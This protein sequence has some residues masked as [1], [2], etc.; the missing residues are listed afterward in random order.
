MKFKGDI[1]ITDPCY[2]MKDGDWSKCNYGESMSRLGLTAYISE[3]TI[4]GD[5]S[6]TTWSTPR[7][8]VEAQLEE[9]NTLC[10]EQYEPVEKYGRGSVQ[11]KIYEDKIFDATLDLKD[12][13]HFCADAGMVA[14]FLLDE[15][16]KYNPDFNYHTNREWT[17]TLIKDFDGDVEYHVD[18]D[19]N[20]HIIGKGNINFF[21]T[22]TGL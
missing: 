15:V 14:V 16:L 7:K 12:I 17:T 21:T 3:S 20:A 8:D 10:R 4:Y 1:I 19:G 18:E 11:E 22:Q 2:I 6:C 5:W 9:I 13:G